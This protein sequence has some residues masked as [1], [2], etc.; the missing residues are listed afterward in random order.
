MGRFLLSY[1][2]RVFRI[3]C[4][5]TAWLPVNDHGCNSNLQVSSDP[6]CAKCHRVQRYAGHADFKYSH[7]FMQFGRLCLLH[8]LH[9]LIFSGVT[10]SASEFLLF[11]KPVADSR[12][13]LCAS[14]CCKHDPSCDLGLAQN[15][16]FCNQNWHNMLKQ[17]CSWAS[18]VV[19]KLFELMRCERRM[20]R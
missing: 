3:W 5:P 1:G 11:Y 4:A 8:D 14:Q 18:N 19:G 9:R 16:T 10:N 20:L 2:S 6:E 7:K 13:N 12:I 17:Q 15:L